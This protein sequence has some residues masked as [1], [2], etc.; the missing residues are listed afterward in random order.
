MR[1][2]LK[3][4]TYKGLVLFFTIAG[5][6]GV[7]YLWSPGFREDVSEFIGEIFLIN[8]DSSSS[9]IPIEGS[10]SVSTESIT[11]S[12]V[13]S[14]S[15]DTFSPTQIQAIEEIEPIRDHFDVYVGNGIFENGTFSDGLAPLTQDWLWDNNHH[16]I[17]RIR[18][19]EYPSGCDVSRYTTDLV[20]I[21]GSDG[22]TFTI[23]GKVM[24]EYKIADYAHG[25]IFKADINI[26]DELCALNFK[27]IGYSIILG[28]DIYH[29]YDSYCYRGHCD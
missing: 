8:T 19:E 2:K 5:P 10:T 27:P 18:Q 15:T 16:R 23:N 1:E 12:P 4:N 26:G 6:I 14:S 22:M 9:G 7:G 20:W 28:P 3:S 25:Y 17:Q 24:G 21:A 11:S 13:P 29:A